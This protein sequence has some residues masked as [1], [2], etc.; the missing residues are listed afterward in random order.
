MGFCLKINKIITLMIV[1][2][3]ALWFLLVVVLPESG[4]VHVGPREKEMAITWRKVDSPAHSQHLSYPE[5][6]ILYQAPP[7]WNSSK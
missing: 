3:A 4:H 5:Y 7:P 6:S 2:L 1:A